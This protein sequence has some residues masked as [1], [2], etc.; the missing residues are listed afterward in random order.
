MVLALENPVAIR[1]SLGASEYGSKE[2]SPFPPLPLGP[3]ESNKLPP[4][5]RQL[6]GPGILEEPNPVLGLLLAPEIL[7]DRNDCC[8]PS[9]EM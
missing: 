1:F 7:A 5:S 3:E 6:L 9:I 2:S 4:F 8:R